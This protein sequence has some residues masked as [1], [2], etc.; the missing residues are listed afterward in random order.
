[1]SPSLLV[2]R[3]R[4]ELLQAELPIALNYLAQILTGLGRSEEAE[5]ALRE[6]REFEARRGGDS[7]W[8]AYNTALLARLL[9]T[10][11]GQARESL[12]LIAERQPPAV[13]TRLGGWTCADSKPATDRLTTR[14]ASGFSVL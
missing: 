14:P 11:P 13:S 5:S 12:R 10:R 3:L 9:A 8:H 1:M 7:G 4:N 6:A 2:G